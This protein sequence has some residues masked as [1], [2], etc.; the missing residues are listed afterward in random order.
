ME[1]WLVLPQ[2]IN[3]EILKTKSTNKLLLF[4]QIE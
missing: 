2:E 1:L 4:L 3:C